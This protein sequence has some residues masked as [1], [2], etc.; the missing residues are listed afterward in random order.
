MAGKLN[1]IAV[2]DYAEQFAQTICDAHYA[3]HSEVKGEQIMQ[4]TPNKQ[5]NLL[6]IKNLFERW[7]EET[8]AIKSPYFSYEEPAIKEA[9][10]KLMNLLSRNI[11]IKRVYFEPLLIASTEDT[12]R[13]LLAPAV[14]YEQEIEKLG[15]RFRL[16]EDFKPLSRYLKTHQK[17]LT[18]LTERFTILADADQTVEVSQAMQAVQDIIKENL[19][20]DD[21]KPA[22]RQ[23]H[24][25]HA[26]R[27]QDLVAK[28]EEPNT[29]RERPRAATPPAPPPA[30]EPEPTSVLETVSPPPETKTVHERIL[31]QTPPQPTVLERQQR[32]PGK[33]IEELIPVGRKM[34]FIQE[35]FKGE[36]H[37]F[38]EVVDKIDH[39]ANYHD[40]IMYIREKYFYK[41]DW[42][43][44]NSEVQ[45]FYSLIEKKFD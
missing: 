45:E 24:Q 33:S 28:P 29:E 22:L 43:L 25:V 42:D 14:F 38:D 9:L 8:E 26:L 16:E 13:L 3:Q 2:T 35:L 31:E 36:Q 21:P 37:V 10:E 12:L 34:A 23:L 20:Y 17:L 27:L 41:Y 7:Q 30:P 5:L 18:K 1:Q 40:A 11:S 19:E 4:I 39:C 32:H 6:I 15:T 44:G